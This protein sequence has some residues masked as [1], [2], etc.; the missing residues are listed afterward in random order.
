MKYKDYKPTKFDNHIAIPDREVWDVVSFIS[1]NRDADALT[2]SNFNYVHE[3][4]ATHFM[5]EREYE[6]HRFKHWASGWFE[7]IIINPAYPDVVRTIN[8]IEE[9]YRNYP[10]LDDLAYHLL[11]AKEVEE[12]SEEE[13]S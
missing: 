11:E 4:L 13:E 6:V 5:E 2:R 7:I 9:E 3:Q 12:E 1:N 8:K 10:V